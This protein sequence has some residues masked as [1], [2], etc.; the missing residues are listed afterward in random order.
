M[1]EE[2]RMI[3]EELRQMNKTMSEM[4][5]DISELKSDVSELKADV[6]VLK[7]DVA[8]LKT[9]VAVLKTDVAVLKTDVAVL[10]TEVSILKS[11]MRT[12]KDDIADLEAGQ[13]DLYLRRCGYHAHNIGAELH[14][15]FEIQGDIHQEGVHIAAAAGL[16]LGIE[17]HLSQLRVH[18]VIE[19]VAALGVVLHD[20][21]QEILVHA[22]VVAQSLGAKGSHQVTG[23]LAR[24]LQFCHSS[25][26][27]KKF[28]TCTAHL[29]QHF[30]HCGLARGDA[31]CY[32]NN[33]HGA[34]SSTQLPPH[35]AQSACVRGNYKKK[36]HTTC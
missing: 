20:A 17:A 34:H 16:G 24:L 15:A 35:Q 9:D 23:Q 25:I 30:H 6:A 33:L 5:S 22:A 27:I 8:V 11:D 21:A 2:T 28:Y 19:L 4:K 26:T 7:T 1:S 31:S 14:R 3:M 29:T 32:N 13:R 18:Q 36:N 12:V 10:K